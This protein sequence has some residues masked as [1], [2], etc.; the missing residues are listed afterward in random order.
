M[1]TKA[2]ESIFNHSFETVGQIKTYKHKHKN[3][4]FKAYLRLN[5]Q[6]KYSKINACISGNANEVSS[7]FKGDRQAKI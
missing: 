1:I 4:I 6:Q 2:F 3:N 7:S 5:N